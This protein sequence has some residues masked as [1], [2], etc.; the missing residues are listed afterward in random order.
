MEIKKSFDSLQSYE[1]TWLYLSNLRP[2]LNSRGLFHDNTEQFLSPCEPEKNSDVVIKFR[3]IRFNADKVILV[4]GGNLYDMTK[5]FHDGKFDYYTATVHLDEEPLYYY[6]EVILGKTTLFYTQLGAHADLNQYYNFVIYPGFKTPEWMRG[7][8]IYQI[9][10]DRFYN[11][12]LSND[13]VDREYT[14][15]GEHVRHVDN[16]DKYPATMGVRE[17]YGGDLDGVIKKLDYLKELGIQ[18]IYFNPLFVSPSNHKYDIQ[19][20]DYIDPHIGKIVDDG[21]EPLPEN[22]YEN[23]QATKYIKRVTALDNLE[24]SN[25]LFIKLVEEAHSR[26]IKV[27]IDG[28]FNHCG[29]FNKWLDR[30][31]IYEGSNDFEKGAYVSGESPYR[32]FF[33]FNDP[34]RWPYNGT[35]NGWWG[36]DTLPKLNYEG[37]KK[38]EEYILSVGRKWVSPPYNVDGWRLDVAADLGF[39]EEYNHNFWK[40]FRNAVKEVNPNAVILAEHYGDCNSWLHGDEWDTIMNYDAFMEPITW[41]LTGM[42]KHSDSYDGN[43]VGNP[44]YFF[45]AMRHNM[46]R[47]GGSPVRISMNELSNH[48]HSRFLTRTNRTVGRTESRGPRAA[49]ENVN[50]AVFMEAVVVQMSWPG[51]PTLYYGDEAGVCGWTDPDNRRTYPW[52][53][54]DMQLIDFH[55]SIIKLHKETPALM[56]GSYKSL[57]GDYNVI[58]FGRFLQDSKA[59]TI[60][61][62]N[63]S[64]RTVEI[65]VWECGV[66]NGDV[67]RQAICTHAD[68]FSVDCGNYETVFG[69]IKITLPPLSGTIL[70]K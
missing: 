53:H 24:A 2:V 42:E 43:K 9:Y 17:F 3:V 44:S 7:A 22:V 64:E 16:W 38:L 4:A 58:A 36:H 57:Y 31:R 28:V 61:N 37:S 30:E 1:K 50:K 13:V 25:A 48:D 70:V 63:D 20:Y 68:G 15:I 41:F 39:S 21:G 8:V 14:Y 51:A 55:K 40:K 69:K 23:V 11:G 60:I 18:C 65:D 47:M 62:N 56:T 26:G 35:Y 66:N 45:D 34:N 27:I 49:E 33:Q 59:I 29:S 10:V 5:S 46:S 67:L 12:D 52:G 32:D 19:D 54:E 6:F